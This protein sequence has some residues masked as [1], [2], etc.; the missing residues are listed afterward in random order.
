[1]NNNFFEQKLG[2]A[3]TTRNWRTTG[4][5]YDMATKG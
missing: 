5:L 1:M 4:I 3:A 2:L